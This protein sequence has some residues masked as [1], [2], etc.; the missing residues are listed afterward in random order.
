MKKTKSKTKKKIPIQTL[1]EEFSQEFDKKLKIHVLPNGNVTYKQ[2]IIKNLKNQNWG[3]FDT[4]QGSLIEQFYL[5]TCALMAAK[6]YNDV[7]LE[8]YHEIKHLDNRYWSNYCDSMIYKKNI[9]RAVDLDHYLIILNR[10]EESDI[11]VK[12][13]KDEISRMFTW[14]FV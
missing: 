9:K 14:S 8:K 10:L 3:I 2:Y 13:Y 1:A 7:R 5:K 11:K 6:A 4:N 12:Y